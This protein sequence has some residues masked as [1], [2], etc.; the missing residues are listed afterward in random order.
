[1]REMLV[2]NLENAGPGYRLRKHKMTDFRKMLH[3]ISLLTVLLLSIPVSA[4]DLSPYIG[5]PHP[6]SLQLKDINGKR[7]SLTDFKGQVVLVNFWAT[8]CPPCRAEMPSMWRLQNGFRGK[9][10]RV[11]AVNMAESDVEVKTFLPDKMKR[12]FIIL[13][14]REGDALKGW[15]VYVSPTSYVIDK[16]GRIRFGL[17]GATEWDSFENRTLIEKLL[18]EK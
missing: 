17:F 9:P 16:Q 8:W 12:D 7:Y 13:M 14:D 11:L 3:A 1:M 2:S 4:R 18:K 15:R 6:P 5:D 10:F